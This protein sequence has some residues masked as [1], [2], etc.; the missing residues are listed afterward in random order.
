MMNK[1][2][3]RLFSR[4]LSLILVFLMYVSIFPVPVSTKAA[5]TSS[6]RVIVGLGDSFSSGEGIEP[7][8]DQDL[9]IEQRIKSQDWLA[10]RSEKAWSGLLTLNDNEKKVCYIMNQNKYD[11]QHPEYETHWYFAATSGAETIHLY[12]EQGKKYH[13]EVNGKAY[14]GSENIAKQLE[15]FE[16]VKKNNQKA[17]YVTLTLGG[18]DVGF[19]EV[20]IS[21]A[22][23]SF[24]V[25]PYKSTQIFREKLTM[26]EMATVKSLELAYRK[27]HETAGTQASII[28]AGYPHLF[29][30]TVNI[31][32]S[33]PTGLLINLR[34]RLAVNNCVDILNNQIQSIV[35]KLQKENI[36]IHYVSVVKEFAGHGAYSLY[37]YI[38]P[39]HLFPKDQDIKQIGDFP[40]PSAY[41]IHPNEKGAEAYARCVQAKIDELEK[42]KYPDKFPENV[43]SQTNP[44]QT[45]VIFT[46]PPPLTSPQPTNNWQSA[47]IDLICNA[48]DYGLELTDVNMSAELIDVTGDYIPEIFFCTGIGATSI[49]SISGYFYYNGSKYVKGTMSGNNGYF[50]ILPYKSGNQ[51][52]FLTGF[53]NPEDIPDEIPGF[54]SYWHSYITTCQLSCSGSN[55]NFTVVAD[56][57]E[58]RDELI[59]FYSEDEEEIAQAE[60][61]WDSYCEEIEDFYYTHPIDP[62][63][64]YV[65]LNNVTLT[66]CST[67]AYKAAFIP[68]DVQ[69]AVNQYATYS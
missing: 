12:S 18:N 15:I 9:P 14:K 5:N 42:Q 6:D 29:N 37:P 44:P 22:K 40:N 69:E 48:P 65:F 23:T 1:K 34:E 28:V 46:Q 49:P 57:S 21:I 36:D 11:E 16:T 56:Y 50:P 20:I 58:Y 41:S 67:E 13:L 47:A 53:R 24:Y 32:S 64:Y 63:C 26:L 7:F 2:S 31:S 54:S 62:N 3:I 66:T 60:Q 51:T 55:I 43:P 25:T 45:T 30:P 61:M 10:H 39:I 38:N 68:F 35:E 4:I 19:T 27:I 59:G 52:I 8:Y 17:D 33:S